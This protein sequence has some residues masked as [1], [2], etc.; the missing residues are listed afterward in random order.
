MVTPCLICDSKAILT[1]G[2][3]MGTALLAGLVNAATQGAQCGR[4]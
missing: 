2:A 4:T 3:A 1:H